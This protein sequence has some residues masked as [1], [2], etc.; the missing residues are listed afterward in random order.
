MNTPTCPTCGTPISLVKLGQI[1]DTDRKRRAETE[2]SVRAQIESEFKRKLEA[3]KQATAKREKAEA[4]KR[5]A[6]I[7]SDRDKA[8]SIVKQLQAREATIQKQAKEE[9][10]KRIKLFQDQA[11]Q[12]KQKDFLEQRQILAKDRDREILKLQAEFNR[13]RLAHQKK[14]KDMDRQLQRKTPNEAGDGAEID[15]YESLREAFPD[16]RISRVQKG[17]AGGD[18]IHEVVNRGQSCGRIIYESKNQAWRDGFITKLL[19]DKEHAE[20]D[21]AILSTSEFKS[22]QKELFVKDGVIVISPARVVQMVLV[23]RNGMIRIHQLGLSTKERASKMSR[24]YQFI[25][26]GDFRQ[27][28]ETAGKLTGDILEL[29]V[30]EHAQHQDAWKQRGLLATRLRNLVAEIDSEIAAILEGAELRPVA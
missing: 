9:S 7:E 19:Q 12:L 21:H 13:E 27:T 20:A 8:L 1:A 16:D 29:D 23:L 6:V 15:L 2:A 17:T 3:E 26:S 14:L 24:L 25:T 5:L 22:G 18:V 28:M 4:T 30:K 11:A 10:D